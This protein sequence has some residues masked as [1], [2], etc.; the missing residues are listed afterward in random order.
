MLLKIPSYQS[1]PGQLL[2]FLGHRHGSGRTIHHHPPRPPPREHLEE[3]LRMESAGIL[4]NIILF[5]PLNPDTSSECRY[6]RMA[7][8][9]NPA[10]MLSGSCR[11]YKSH[12]NFDHEVK[13]SLIR[14]YS[15]RVR[16]SKLV[17]THY[18]YLTNQVSP[19]PR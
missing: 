7:R 14:L 3:I 11:K 12:E 2:V 17:K 15:C 6:P 5:L 8:R 13:H 16:K 18:S 9:E 1:A 10:T 19:D 4:Y